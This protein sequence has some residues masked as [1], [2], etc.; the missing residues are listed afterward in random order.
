M[1][2]NRISWQ[3][4]NAKANHR[5]N[6]YS[7]IWENIVAIIAESFFCSNWPK[8]YYRKYYAIVRM[9]KKLKSTQWYSIWPIQL[10]AA[11]WIS[12][13]Y[14]NH[15]WIN[16]Q[17]NFCFVSHNS[18]LKVWPIVSL[19]VDFNVRFQIIAHNILQFISNEW[20][21]TFFRLSLSLLATN[22]CHLFSAI[23]YRLMNIEWALWISLEL[24]RISCAIQ[25][26]MAI[27]HQFNKIMNASFNINNN[28][29]ERNKRYQNKCSHLK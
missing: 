2:S 20:Y 3:N 6:T 10:S 15:V 1:Q 22:L 28:N 19:R 8:W 24:S 5:C 25:L 17:I 11:L 18:V 16:E 26:Y 13:I 29:N 23:R 9:R 12:R 21:R 14:F 7:Y 4:T 27:A